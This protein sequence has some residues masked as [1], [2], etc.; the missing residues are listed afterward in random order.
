MTYREFS[1]VLKNEPDQDQAKVVQSLK[2]T[3]VSAGA[4]SGKTQTLANRFAYLITADLADE[5]GN[6]VKNPTVERI[7]T[8]TFTNKAAAEM[9]QRI[10]Q[11]LKFFAQNAPTQKGRERAQKAI[12]DFSKARI[13]TL[14]SYSAGILRQAAAL[15]GIRPDFSC[16]SDGSKIK[17][18][19]FDFVLEN[20]KSQAVQWIMEPAKFEECAELFASAALKNTSLADSAGGKDGKKNCG[21]FKES[22]KKQKDAIEKKWRAQKHP[23]EE[24][25]EI[26]E[27]IK[28][29]FPEQRP[30]GRAIA[31]FDE[32][33]KRIREWNDQK[34][35]EARAFVKNFMKQGNLFDDPQKLFD[36][37]S[38]NEC[39]KV[40]K[41]LNN[42]K[43]GNKITDAYISDLVKNKLFGEDKKQTGA[44]KEFLGLIDF[45][46]DIKYLQEL[47]PL[48]DRFADKANEQKRKT[49]ELTFKD[50]NELALLA[51]KEQDALRK[52]ER[53]SYDFIMIDEFQ[54]NNGP[55]RDLL[56]L[57]SEDDQ[58]RVM[59]NRLFFVGDEKQSIYKFRGADVSVFNGLQ[60]YLPDCA[61]LPM[62]RN[63]RS[64]STLIDGFN[65]IFGGYLPSDNERPSVNGESAKI[66]AEVPEK[67]YQAKF[68]DSSRA[69]FPEHKEPDPQG[70]QPKIHVCLYSSKKPDKETQLSISETQALFAAKKIWELKN[71]KNIDFKD[72]A[73]LAKSRTHYSEIARIFTEQN[74]PFSLD[75]QGK[76]FL[77]ATANDFYNVLR[78]CVY[79]ADLNAFLA[80]L[81][82][83]FAGM[84]LEDAEKILSLNP[85]KA[86]DAEIDEQKLLDG[87]PLALYQ[88]AKSFFEDFS[89]YAL[90]SPITNSIE[91]LW[92]KEGYKFWP[93]ANEE[94]Y[95]LLFELA[96]SSDVDG[97]DLSWFVDQLAA[98]KDKSFDDED[99]ELDIKGTEYPVENSNAVNIMTIHKSKGLEFDWVFVL[100]IAEPISGG[101]TDRSKIFKTDDY[102]SVVAN[103]KKNQNFFAAAAISEDESKDNAEARRLL[104]VALT[105]AAKELFI[106]GKTPSSDD[107]KN[108][109]VPALEM[110]YA[111]AKGSDPFNQTLPPAPFLLE[112]L[113][114]QQRGSE[115]LE[116]EEEP[117]SL[118]EKRADWQNA[119]II[120]AID[121]QNFWTTPSALENKCERPQSEQ[122]QSSAASKA[123]PQIN[124]F[125]NESA[126]KKNEY[127]TLFHAFMESWSQNW[128]DWTKE[129]IGA[130]EY[131][132]GEPLVQKL[133]K[134]NQEILLDTF[135]KI[136]D[137][138]ISADKNPAPAALQAGRPFR[139][140]Y[141]FKT[142]IDSYIIT[143]SMDA[144][145]QNQD[146]TWTILDY[147]TDLAP[148]ASVY[149]NQLAV[150]KKAAA[151]LFADGDLDKINCVLFFS[152]TGQLVDI[153]KESQEALKGLNDEK[154][155]NLIEKAKNL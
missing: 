71:D 155:F 68:D 70:A 53:D 39:L 83:P 24:I 21:V 31:W 139:A 77:S 33:P 103:G 143:G 110:I 138:F 135:F 18:L 46:S 134:E 88:K 44:A 89:S 15:Y 96:R 99:Q 63:Y 104:Y 50:T 105:R 97:K 132:E 130:A 61:T 123:Y 144:V 141:R 121:A 4:G 129:K 120:P 147:K 116:Q 112:D 108:Q 6:A 47:H 148:D 133:S 37:A 106:L 75:Q 94:H 3:I 154:I 84:K 22:L 127:G 111:Y 29:N 26:I 23:L 86:F 137:K 102:G 2:N 57:I 124:S 36:F 125:V 72:V 67:N 87:E 149:Y 128:Q 14:D 113:P 82:S 51:L 107:N 28:D 42:F 80:F 136:L 145:F 95:D 64:C 146:G 5:N 54:D 151:D 16:G 49:G 140:E 1:A 142:K 7:L 60:A 78:L 152:E 12:D 90:S 41:A 35:Q 10:Y 43:Y 150:Y 91:R 58:G 81:N 59:K 56:L 45:F 153:S 66:F 17:S 117:K 98:E 65:Q 34:I 119:D 11:T 9:Y 76:I 115:R 62:R 131:F 8:L 74:I 126:L 32:I 69:R 55:N 25:E 40:I 93:N 52:Q 79:P 100:G 92:Q 73:V 48:L 118:Q 30:T 20:R 109:K 85:K 13:Q 19:A 27:D 38:S 114:P 101:K 122:E